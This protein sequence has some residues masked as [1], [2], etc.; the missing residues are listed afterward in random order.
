MRKPRSIP[1]PGATDCRRLLAPARHIRGMQ[2]LPETPRRSELLRSLAQSF[3]QSRRPWPTAGRNKKVG[4]ERKNR[5]KKA[6]RNIVSGPRNG[7]GAGRSNSTAGILSS[8]HEL[9]AANYSQLIAGV[10]TTRRIEHQN[11]YFAM[12]V[13][14]SLETSAIAAR[15]GAS[16]KLI[17]TPVNLSRTAICAG[18]ALS[19][20]NTYRTA[21]SS[22]VG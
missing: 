21:S 3:F 14:L 12:T 7:A 11:P 20:V 6:I 15:S 1:P 2:K 17:C 4:H 22:T 18:A 9:P 19:D 16:T 10:K 8:D 13:R 5:P